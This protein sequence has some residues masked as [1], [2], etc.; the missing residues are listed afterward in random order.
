MNDGGV[1]L[2]SN[3]SLMTDHVPAALQF[4]NLS[5]TLPQYKHRVLDSVSGSVQPGQLLAIMGASGAG[6]ST[7]LDILA[8]R[9]KMGIVAGAVLVNGRPVPDGVFRRAA[10]Y[11]DQEDTLMGTLTVYETV[12]YSALL[13]LPRE[14]SASAKRFRTLQTLDELGIL[15]IRDSRIGDSAGG[16]RGISGGEKRRVSIACELVTSPSILFLD[17]PTSGLDAYN[18]LSVVECLHRLAREFKRTVIFTIHQPRSN[19]V[20]LFDRLVVLA[21]GR[22]VYSGEMAQ[23]QQYFA[24]VGYPCPS[25]FNIADYLSA[26]RSFG[27][28]RV[29]LTHSCLIQSTRQWNRTRILLALLLTVRTMHALSLQLSSTLGT[30][31]ATHPAR[32]HPNA[33]SFTGSR[34][35]SSHAPRFYSTAV[36]CLL[37]TP[38]P[39]PPCLAGRPLPIMRNRV[40]SAR[41]SLRWSRPTA[42]PMLHR[43]FRLRSHWLRTEVRP[44]RMG[45]Y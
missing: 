28:A 43:A 1:K 24:D 20:S 40:H 19:I 38:S 3:D 5:Y 4:S 22:V 10:G 18:A 11:V 42:A 21:K 34:A 36:P 14:M 44:R 30:Q 23:A 37:A 39:P 27:S 29:I 31:K 2:P 25:G 9:Q 26:F 35:T 45:H 8:R 33:T 17:E 32:R 13:R 6:K 41:A 12:Y 15:S 16:H 7:L